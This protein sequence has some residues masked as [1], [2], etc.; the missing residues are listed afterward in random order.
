MAERS[1]ASSAEIL[2]DSKVAF[3]QLCHLFEIMHKAKNNSIRKQQ[4]NDFVNRWKKIQHSST[5][6]K[7]NSFFPAF[8]LILPQLD[9][10]RLSYGVKEM[11]LAKLYI[12]VLGLSKSGQ[13][14]KKLLEYRN[15]KRNSVSAGDFAEIAFRHVLSKRCISDGKLTIAE[16]NQFLDDLAKYNNEKRKDMVKKTLLNLIQKTSSIEQKW[17]IRIMLKDTKLKLGHKIMLKVFHPDAEE[18]YNITTSLR[19][20]CERLPDIDVCLSDAEIELFQPF[21]PMLALNAKLEEIEKLMDYKPFLIEIK[22]DGERSQVH[23]DGKQYKYFSRNGKEYS[24]VFGETPYKGTITPYIHDCFSAEV[25]SCI[26]DG[27][28]MGYHSEMK[29]FMQ[30][31]AQFDIKHV[32]EDSEL[33][34]CLVVFDLLYLN[35]KRLTSLSQTERHEKL[36][37]VINPVEGRLQFSED[38]Q[39]SLNQ[40]VVR[41]L[42]DAI[43]RREEGI[44]VKHPEAKYAPNKRKGSGWLKIKPEYT[45]GVV[46][47]LDLVIIG[48]SFGS[49][50]RG[51]FLST[52]LLGVAVKDSNN[53]PPDGAI[54]FKSL[55]RVGSGYTDKQLLEIIDKLKP[56][57][58]VF[59]KKKIPDWMK[60][61]KE[62]PDVYIHPK[63]SLVVQIRA[64]EIIPSTSY[65]AGCTLRFPRLV[66]VRNDKD[67]VDALDTSQL[68][69]LKNIAD[70]KLAARHADLP[71]EG[72]PPEKKRK[73]KTEAPST[74]SIKYLG[75]DLSSVEQTSSSFQGR[76]FCI[77]TGSKDHDKQN[78]E[79]RVV[80]HGGNIVQNPVSDTFCVVARDERNIKVKNVIKCGKYNV[81][82]IDWLIGCL[83][84][85]MIVPWEP[86]DM[87]HATASTELH[88]KQKYDKYGDDFLKDLTSDTLKEIFQKISDDDVLEILPKEDAKD[89]HVALKQFLTSVLERYE[90]RGFADQPTLLFLGMNFYFCQSNIDLTATEYASVEELRALVAFYGGT[91]LN[92]LDNVTH[93][94]A[95]TCIVD[96]KNLRDVFEFRQSKRRKFYI[97]NENWIKDCLKQGC[98]ICE[99][100][101]LLAPMLK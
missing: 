84:K 86:Q 95:S 51:N 83:K 74:I 94:V 16:I 60:V 35:G 96:D 80:E 18:V 19:Q 3:N 57:M 8:R 32:T 44:I 21:R 87:L 68:E 82:K 85:G 67:F 89:R 4:F 15:P 31:G 40:D 20:V 54:V 23:K 65:A 97:V 99:T 12:D 92:S 26:L 70:G 63:D 27:E 93:V 24:T 22:Y 2:T 55:C 29:I 50:R 6:V 33:Q 34:P 42:N 46:D 88:F 81:V 58:K 56:N 72:S 61:T 25:Q 48:G 38:K 59:N 78:L 36:R 77:L 10:E 17:L 28:M 79:K 43:D 73:V 13:D 49:G 45:L 47:D 11:L 101:Y 100:N 64:S 14:A 71:S 5:S 75:V 53:K 1:A 9:K 91:I 62:K 41:Y 37:S 7:S 90:S 98:I 52:F 39:A 76:V 69:D 66:A 30:K